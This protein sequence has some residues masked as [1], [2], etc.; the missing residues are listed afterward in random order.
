M[1]TPTRQGNVADRLDR[2][3]GD[4]LGREHGTAHGEE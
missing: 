3:H 1:R 4:V 2:G